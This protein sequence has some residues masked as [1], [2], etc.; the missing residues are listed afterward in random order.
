M[1][2][3]LRSRVIP[4]AFSVSLIVASGCSTV[5]YRANGEYIDDGESRRIL[6]Q[7]QAQKYHI[8]FSSA[9][10]DYG[11]VSLQAECIV[12]TFL[13]HHNDPDLGLIFLE[14]PQ[15]YNLVDGAPE[16]RTG[17]YIVCAKLDGNQSIEDLI[18][19]ETV[20]LLVLCESRS[21][22]SSLPASLEGYVLTVS[23]GG[24]EE[25]LGCD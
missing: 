4:I 22:A 17:N 6:L 12:D 25:T 21:N 5:L 13:D 20:E 14:L 18:S 8:P 2:Q 24:L 23:S 16:L 15:D 3:T 7:W 1:Q 19:A 11:S 10:V 9:T